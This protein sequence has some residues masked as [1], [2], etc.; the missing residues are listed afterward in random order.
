MDEPSKPNPSTKESA[1]NCVTGTVKCCH[2]PGKSINFKSMNFIL[3]VLIKLNTL[4]VALG[5]FAILFSFF[6]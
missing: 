4:S 1:S 5:D 6:Y 2:C 3:F